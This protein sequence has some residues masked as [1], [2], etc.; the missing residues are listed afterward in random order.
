LNTRSFFEGGVPGV[1]EYFL[2]LRDWLV[3]AAGLAVPIL[4]LAHFV[5]SRDLGLFGPP[6]QTVVRWTGP[7]VAAAF[8]VSM[9]TARLFLDLFQQTE[10]LPWM[11]GPGP[12]PDEIA[13]LRRGLWAMTAG[14]PAEVIGVVLL[15][16]LASDTRPA[17]L[18]LTVQRFPSNLLAGLLYWL[19]LMPA[20]LLLHALT[21]RL[22]KYLTPF[23]PE[24]HAIQKLISDSPVLADWVL[25]ALTAILAAPLREE[26]LY[27]GV[28]QQWAACQA[29]RGDIVVGISLFVAVLFRQSK[30]AKAWQDGTQAQ[31][32]WE[33]QPLYFVLALLPVYMALRRWQKT[34]APGAIFASAL[35]F[36]IYHA[37]VWPSPIPLFPLGLT[38]GWLAYR[39]QG[40]VAPIVVHMLFNTV[41]VLG[42]LHQDA[43]LP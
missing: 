18:G 23:A 38:L 17:Q 43:R 39:T 7:E 4:W 28:L 37:E 42:L 27:R 33:L 21:L 13:R 9:L 12:W 11:Y 8:L 36:A 40:L 24:A 6:Q 20:I 35:L 14:L 41:A 31:L 16:Q 2:L 32:I 25:T 26:L 5:R 1:H 22:Y 30:V 3:L 29:R 19:V 10:L 15:M 34:P